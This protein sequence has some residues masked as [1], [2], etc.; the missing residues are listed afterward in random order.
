[1]KQQGTE[2]ETSFLRKTESRKKSGGKRSSEDEK[3]DTQKERKRNTKKKT[4]FLAN[5][6][7]YGPVSQKPGNQFRS[8]F[9]SVLVVATHHSNTQ[10]CGPLVDVFGGRD[11]IT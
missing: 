6:S 11:L 3:R 9:G 8:H 10:K 5:S 2:R 1:M 7:A 4:D